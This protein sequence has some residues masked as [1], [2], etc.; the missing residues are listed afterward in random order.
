MKDFRWRLPRNGI[1]KKHFG[2]HKNIQPMS[3]RNVDMKLLYLIREL[4]LTACLYFK[5]RAITLI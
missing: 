3:M 2:R 4:P 5:A 1:S